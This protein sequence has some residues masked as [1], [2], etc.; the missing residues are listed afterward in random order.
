MAAILLVYATGEGQTATV[1]DRITERLRDAG[2]EVT[3]NN[4]ADLRGVDLADYDAVLLGAS[5]HLGKAQ[6][7]M[8]KFART[9][10][11]ALDAM[12][13]G[14]FEVSLSAAS[15]DPERQAEA[16]QYVAEFREATGWEPDIVGIFGGAFRYSQ[17]GFLKRRLMKRIAADFTGDTDA[18]RDYEYTDWDAVTAFTDDFAAI[19]ETSEPTEATP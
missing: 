11:D 5:I 9:H 12:P 7:S 2:H 6:D 13:N 10:R 3:A 17:Y 1:A 18:S 16:R 4:V 14:F 15:E 8:V 19:V